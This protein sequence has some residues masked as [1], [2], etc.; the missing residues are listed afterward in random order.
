[1]QNAKLGFSTSNSIISRL[2]R[3]FTKA[4]VSHTFLTVEFDGKE[5]VLE[6]ASTGYRIMP[7]SRFV[8]ENSLVMII[9]PKVSLDAAVTQAEDWLGEGYDW[10]GLLGFTWVLLGR[11]LKRKWANPLNSSKALFCSEANTKI[12][13]L[14][15]WPGSEALVPSATS[16]NDLLMFARG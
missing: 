12:I 2:I 1:M 5:W 7:L 13:Q 14:A 6:A 10:G 9:E 15:G 3:W 11:L 16:P 4:S 8:N